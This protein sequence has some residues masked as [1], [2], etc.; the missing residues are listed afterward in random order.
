VR[1]CWRAPSPPSQPSPL[2]PP[3]LLLLLLPWTMPPAALQR[4]MP[5]APPAAPAAGRCC[6][7]CRCRCC[8]SAAWSCWS[9]G[10]CSTSNHTPAAAPLNR[11]RASA[12]GCV[13]RV[14]VRLRVAAT[15]TN[16]RAKQTHHAACNRSERHTAPPAARRNA[17]GPTSTSVTLSARPAADSADNTAATNGASCD[18][19]QQRQGDSRTSAPRPRA[20]TAVHAC[21]RARARLHAQRARAPPGC[22]QCTCAQPHAPAGPP[23]LRVCC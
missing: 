8:G 17:P 5:H 15:A 23:V 9:V 11:Q 6:C 16:G 14:R 1:C 2:Q 13:Q 4:L 22:T 12:L 3:P 20:H 7:S 21:A 18:R 19:A 10:G